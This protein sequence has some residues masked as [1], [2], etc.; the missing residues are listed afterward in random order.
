MPTKKSKINENKD[1][2]IIARSDDGTVQITFTIPFSEIEEARNK[3]AKELGRDLAVPGF[4]K[5]MAPLSKVIESIPDNTLLEKCL[6][7]ILPDLV[8]KVIKE[9][10]LKPVIYPKFELVKAI[11]GEDW[12]IRAITCE[13]NPVELSDYRLRPRFLIGWV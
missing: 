3:A 9:N 1:N 12:Q 4:R 6:S 11:D 7:F 10:D 13:L 5:G 2:S 8:S